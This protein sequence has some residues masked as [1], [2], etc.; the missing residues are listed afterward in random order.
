MRSD[1]GEGQAGDIPRTGSLRSPLTSLTA[2]FAHSSFAR[3]PCI[4]D[5][6]AA[7]IEGI[8]P[9]IAWVRG[10][11]ETYLQGAGVKKGAPVA[12]DAVDAAD[13]VERNPSA[14]YAIEDFT[15]VADPVNDPFP[16]I[17][18]S[19]IGPTEQAPFA[20]FKRTLTMVESTPVATGVSN[21]QIISY[22]SRDRDKG[23]V[24]KTVGGFIETAAFGS[25]LIKDNGDGTADVD[26]TSSG[27]WTAELSAAASSM[28]PEA[29]FSLTTSG[30][31]DYL[32]FHANYFAPGA[33]GDA[34][35][36]ND[37]FLLADGGDLENV[38]L[39]S[40][41]L[42]GVEKIVLF[43]D[44]ELPLSPYEKYNP[45]TRLPTP[46]DI[47]DL[48]SYFGIPQIPQDVEDWFD[49]FGQDFSKNKVFRTIHYPHVVRELQKAQA[50]GNGAVATVKL[51]T[52]DND[53]WG[54][55]GGQ[56]VQVTFVY[57]SKATEFEDALPD[58]V[59]EVVAT[60]TNDPTDLIQD[61]PFKYFPHYSTGAAEIT[62]KQANLLA[63]MCAW[64]VEKNVEIFRKALE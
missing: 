45:W 13:F 49:Y 21:S 3:K 37:D 36:F 43:M 40:F 57:L 29:F 23:T 32:G 47:E 35:T 34:D 26:I 46:E 4:L 17:G 60:G 48:P 61:G 8:P 11:Y 15:T 12:W 25:E 33:G 59:K 31:A 41:L 6:A 19:L 64:V 54:V 42:R 1:E 55:K 39:I 53:W 56:E 10:I 22:K 16:L 5:I 28:A 44:F 63:N 58:E 20:P 7:Y 62:Y 2:R 14:G 9:Y 38:N 50:T 27:P 24:E 30:I 51:T 18:F 52:V